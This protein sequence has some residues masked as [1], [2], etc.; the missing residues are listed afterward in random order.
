MLFMDPF[1]GVLSQQWLQLMLK[2]LYDLH[3]RPCHLACVVAHV[4][5]YVCK[6]ICMYD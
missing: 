5:S 2:V 6:S 4:H 3:I 1:C